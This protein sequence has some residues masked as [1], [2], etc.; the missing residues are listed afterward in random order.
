M[1]LRGNRATVT[2][3]YGFLNRSAMT[4]FQANVASSAQA[5]ILNPSVKYGIL[6]NP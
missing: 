4:T 3:C 2:N 6:K 1:L 5:C